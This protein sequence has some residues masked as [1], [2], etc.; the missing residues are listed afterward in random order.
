M[1]RSLSAAVS[2]R[3]SAKSPLFHRWLAPSINGSI[4][5]AQPAIIANNTLWPYLPEVACHKGITS[6][7]SERNETKRNETKWNETKRN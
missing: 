2:T 3:F 7:Q 1:M 6:G 4:F 5:D